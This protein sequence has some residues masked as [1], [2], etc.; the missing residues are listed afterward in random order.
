MNTNETILY[1]CLK[2]VPKVFSTITL[3][4]FLDCFGL[5]TYHIYS[6]L[7]YNIQTSTFI[8]KEHK[9]QALILKIASK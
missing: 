7:K 2:V 1:C 6:C 9:D 4:L 8:D 3:E 5:L